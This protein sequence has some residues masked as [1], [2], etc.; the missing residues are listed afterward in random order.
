MTPAAKKWL[1]FGSIALVG[2]GLYGLISYQ[3]KLL[4]NYCYKIAY[5]NIVKLSKENI[6]IRLDMW[7]KNLSNISA[8][9]N[10][11]SV[12]ILIN[13]NYVTTV[14]SDEKQTLAANGISKLIMNINF[15][16]SKTM[17]LVEVGKLLVYAVSD[18]KNFIIELD[19]SVNIK[20]SF[21]A[22]KGVPLKMKFSLEEYLTDSVDTGIECKIP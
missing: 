10:G 12:K 11:Y 6:V 17:S 15:N 22:I 4:K 16:P 5:F 1:I 20:H 14:S 3:I 7:I 8:T 9:V 13:G 2:I 21:I 18:K 19:G